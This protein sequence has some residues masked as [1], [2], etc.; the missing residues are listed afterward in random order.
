MTTDTRVW[1]GD[2]HA[3]S[4]RVTS[5]AGTVDLTGATVRLVADPMGTGTTADLPCTVAG[6]VVT[7]ELDGNLT[8]GLYRVVV[9]ATRDGDVV[10]YP[11][12]ATGP[13]TL[14]VRTD[15]G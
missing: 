9:E 3:V 15:V 12:A 7:H 5:A 8:P 1:Q 2:R 4:W 6:D 13:L 14:T 10:T 11:D